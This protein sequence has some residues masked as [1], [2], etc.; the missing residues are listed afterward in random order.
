MVL[1]TLKCMFLVYSHGNVDK[2]KHDDT[3]K[4]HAATIHLII[5]Y[6]RNEN[7]I[8]RNIA[9][10]N[11]RNITSI[12]QSRISITYHHYELMFFKRKMQKL[13]CSQR[14]EGDCESSTLLLIT[15]KIAF[16]LFGYDLHRCCEIYK[17][18]LLS[19]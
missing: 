12:I 17:K 15:G 7:S 3:R 14:H 18:K 1:K 2:K 5:T 16:S 9:A 4:K 6:I 10:W 8:M 11:F 19:T 13:R